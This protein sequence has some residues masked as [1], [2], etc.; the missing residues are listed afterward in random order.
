MNK[1]RNINIYMADHSGLAG[2]AMVHKLRVLSQRWGYLIKSVLIGEQRLAQLKNRSLYL[3]L[4]MEASIFAMAYTGAYLLRFEFTLT[5][6]NLGQIMLVLPWL[7]PLKLAVFSAFGL[8]K[9]MWRYSSLDDLWRL[10]GG[11]LLSTLLIV[12]N[13]FFVYGLTGFSRAVFL[14]DGLLTFVMTGGVRMAIRTYYASKKSSKGEHVWPFPQFKHSPPDRER[15]LII[16]AGRSGEKILREIFDNPHLDHE[17]IGFLDDDPGKKGRS[18]HGVPV[19]GAVDLLPEVLRKHEVDQVFI[20]TPSASGSEMRRIIAICE[21]C[22]AAFK[23]LPAIGQILD[24]QVSIKALRDVDYED[25]L[26]RAPVHLDTAG[27]QD[28]LS[29]RSIM[30]TGAGGSIGS[31]LCRQLVRFDPER[32]ILVDAAEANLYAIQMELR[33]ECKFSAYHA[34]LCRVQHRKTM[35][36][37]FKN[38]RPDVIFH[39]AAYKHV[40]ILELNPLEAVFNNVLGSQTV[41]NLAAQYGTRHFVLVSTDK[42]VRPT[43]VM[44]ASKRLTELILQSMKGS[45]TRFMAVRFGNVLASSGSVIPLFRKQ[46]EHGGPVTVTHP[47]VTRYFMTIPEAACLILA[48]GAIGEGGEIFVLQMGS[49]VKIY[50]MA[51]DLIRL[52]GKQPGKDIEILFTGLRP[53][54]KLYEELITREEDVK[55]TKHDKITVLKTNGHWN[56]NGHGDQDR[57]RRWLNKELKELYAIGD[58][59]EDPA[60]IREK[61]HAI[62]PEYTPQ[63]TGSVR[64]D[65]SSIAQVSGSINQGR[66]A[67]QCCEIVHLASQGVV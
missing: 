29:G 37:I 30:V 16:G 4:L 3:M 36:K 39:A 38:Y 45:G 1:H 21:G 12:V 50:E 55:R 8:Y 43:N 59:Y 24:G 46:I 41:M 17:V 2:S 53:G 64:N 58:R 51:K 15:I 40:P 19:F 52:S 20:S 28:Y 42:A 5:P 25:L 22:R 66:A 34:V 10:A 54:E 27:M 18:I 13:V 11:C 57:F 9:G 61:L 33:H 6:R 47:E 35:E 32:L 31:E 26:R 48:A 63:E 44:G 60:D 49:P 23:T 14:L 7:I 67:S 65:L 62:I 56:W